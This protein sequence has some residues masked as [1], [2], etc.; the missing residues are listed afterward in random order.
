MLQLSH[1]GIRQALVRV[2][3]GDTM[4]ITTI[5]A[6]EFKRNTA[7]FIARAHHHEVVITE[8]GTPRWALIPGILHASRFARAN[9][10]P[11]SRGLDP[12]DEFIARLNFGY[13]DWD[14]ALWQGST[15]LLVTDEADFCRNP[16]PL[17]EQSLT[18]PVT[19][20]GRETGYPVVL[21]SHEVYAERATLDDRQA[22]R[23]QDMPNQAMWVEASKN[24]DL[25]HLD[26]S[27]NHLFDPP[28]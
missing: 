26:A 20:I 19:I 25:G 27:L 12:L 7:E 14:P 6:D 18:E 11:M 3:H 5:G 28:A 8:A 17:M 16:R 10:L 22:F 21:Q 9:G 24:V 1:S 13:P 15:P 2:Q 23:M 4:A